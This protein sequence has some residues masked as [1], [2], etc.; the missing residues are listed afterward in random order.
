MRETKRIAMLRRF[1]VALPL[2]L[3]LASLAGCTLYEAPADPH[4]AAPCPPP[5]PSWAGG[6]AAKP[7]CS[8][9]GGLFLY[10]PPF[11]G[12]ALP[13][14]YYVPGTYPPVVIGGNP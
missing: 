6:D 7:A 14:Y 3:S 2:A 10:P 12:D 5:P 11:L 4:A 8:P 1:V 9:T 13:R